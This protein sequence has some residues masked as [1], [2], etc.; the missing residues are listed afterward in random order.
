MQPRPKLAGTNEAGSEAKTGDKS[1][2]EDSHPR[3]LVSVKLAKELGC[4]ALHGQRVEQSRSGEQS[5]VTGR[6]D[7][8]QDD[9]IDDA[10]G[11]LGAGHLEN[12]GK[13]RGARGLGVETGVV[14]GDVEADEEHGEDTKNVDI[15]S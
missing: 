11:S 2:R 6:Q 3:H 15:S 7:T 10:A 13:G 5:V 8:G 4:V 14:V 12:N 9:G 1:S